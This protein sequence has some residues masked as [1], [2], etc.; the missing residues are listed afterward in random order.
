MKKLSRKNIKALQE[1]IIADEKSRPKPS[2]KPLKLD[3]S[4]EN[5]VKLLG[6]SH[7]RKKH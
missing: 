7:F 6:R 4:F 3:I 2:D 5:A 1:Q